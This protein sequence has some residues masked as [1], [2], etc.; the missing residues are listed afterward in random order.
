MGGIS[1]EQSA[2]AATRLRHA[3]ADSE[4]VAEFLSRTGYDIETAVADIV[5]N[6]IDAGASRVVV[7]LIL[8]DHK[9]AMIA[10]ADNGSGMTISE[11]ERA[12]SL[13]KDPR[14]QD[15]EHL[16]RYGAGLKAASFSL[17]RML[18]VATRTSRGQ[19]RGAILDRDVYKRKYEY[20]DMD[21]EAAA[22]ILDALWGS[23]PLGPSGT[24]V[25]IGD[26]VSMV[27]TS[28][29]SSSLL[30]KRFNVELDTRLGLV[31]HRF[32]ESGRVAIIKS[33]RHLRGF[34]LQEEFAV[35]RLAPVNPFGYPKTGF[36]RYPKRLVVRTGG[37]RVSVRLHVWPKQGRTKSERHPLYAI[38]GR[39]TDWQGLYF[40]RWDR[41]LQ[42]GGWNG[43]RSPEPHSSYARVEVDLPLGSDDEFR[44]TVQ[45]DKIENARPLLEALMKRPEWGPYMAAADSVARGR[46]ASASKQRVA[47]AR[48]R[49]VPKRR[50]KFIT[51]VARPSVRMNDGHVEL[52]RRLVRRLGRERAGAVADLVW[53]AVL[54][55]VG[56]KRWSP[57]ARAHIAAV[58]SAVARLAGREEE[59][60][61]GG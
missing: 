26:L 56:K 13:S 19:P 25:L 20:R 54:P 9:P 8:R 57:E 7:S 44:P 29:E 23:E 17:G 24:V 46:T 42:A 47:K 28:D 33:R 40:Y 34:R 38:L 51:F 45:K 60:I 41:L 58:E 12:A 61:D 36:R 21:P 50:V 39:S 55:H 2:F 22:A 53:Q 16:G 32:I 59:V 4:T 27:P 37:S 31:Y 35:A 49:A 14:K 30:S 48:E 6:S 1:S 18:Y 5:D 10:I 3:E 11:L 43:L 15:G 52:D